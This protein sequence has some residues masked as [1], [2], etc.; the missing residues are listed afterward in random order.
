[1][2]KYLLATIAVGLFGTAVSMP[3][4]AQDGASKNGR[5]ITVDFSDLNIAD[6]QD[7]QSLR[8]RIDTAVR[9]VCPARIEGPVK[10]YRL[11]RQASWKDA[12]RQLAKIKASVMI[13]ELASNNLS[14]TIAS[15][16][17]SRN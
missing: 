9:K 16:T 14:V 7:L 17:R 6:S 2:N 12:E 11:C 13:G 5:A 4:Y 10:M 1:M 3:V 8:S 15:P